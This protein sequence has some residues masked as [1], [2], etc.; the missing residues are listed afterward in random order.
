MDNMD[1]KQE[2]EFTDV[3]EQKL[4]SHLAQRFPSVVR[5]LADASF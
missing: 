3:S 5:R 1:D 2:Y 4:V